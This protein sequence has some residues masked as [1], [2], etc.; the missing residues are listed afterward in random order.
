M[1][2]ALDSPLAL[3]A[4]P[5]R[6]ASY[7]LRGPEP[8]KVQLLIHADVGEN[9][10]G[11][12]VVSLGY[13]ITDQKGSIVESHAADARL[14]PVMQGVPSPLQFTGG[15]SLPPGEYVLRLSVADGDRVGTLEHPVRA[16][17]VDAGDV[18]LSEFTVGGPVDD[19]ELL[20]PTVGYTISFGSV[21]GYLEAYGPRAAN[22]HVRYEI[23]AATDAPALL[24]EEVEARTVSSDRAIFS[25]IMAVRQLPPGKYVLRAV[26]SLESAEVETI[27]RAFEIAAPAVLM[28]SAE[29]ATRPAVSPGELFLPVE[30]TLL[31]HPFNRDAVSRPEVVQRFRQRLGEDA[32]RPFDSGIAQLTSGDFVRAQESFRQALEADDDSTAP[33]VYLAATFAST[34]RDLDA[35]GAWQTSLVNG[36]DIPEIYQWLGDSLMRARDYSKA[37]VVLDEAVEKWPADPRF[38]KPLALMSATFG[39]GREAVRL[40]QR[41]LDHSPND[42]EALALGVE[43]FY[44]LHTAGVFARSRAEDAKLARTYAEAYAKTKGRHAELVKQWMAAIESR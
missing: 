25:N 34:G 24:D 7:S 14:Q 30:E 21:L 29:N 26:V 31:T 13:L 16:A 3:S 18:Q 40:L 41:H 17:L 10:S 36:S 11:S 39:Q 2:A 35:A 33:L 9:Y 6:V 44:H 23:A 5:L 1:F 43:W 8:S 28:T 37:R 38:A 27:T 32:R 15:A 12:R 22:L 19:R 42:A 4:L 20:R